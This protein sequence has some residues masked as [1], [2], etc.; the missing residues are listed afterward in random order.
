[1][2]PDVDG[3]REKGDKEKEKQMIRHSSIPPIRLYRNYEE[4]DTFDTD[5]I[6]RK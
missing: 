2:A 5:Q 3:K 6:R 4:D 1:M